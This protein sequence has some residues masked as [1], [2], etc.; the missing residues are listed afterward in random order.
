MNDQERRKAL[1]QFLQARRERLSPEAVGLPTS[2]RRRTP[3]LR[4]EE[5]ALIAG[6]GLTWYTMLEQGRD[7]HVSQQIL[8]SLAQ[9]LQLSQVERAHLFSLAQQSIV[10]APSMPREVVSPFLQRFLDQLE[11]GPAY[12]TGRRWDLLAWNRA[13]CEVLGDFQVL[14]EAE[15]NIVWFIFTDQEFRRRVGDWEGVAQRVLAQFRVSC[16]QGPGDPRFADLIERL[17][18]RREEIRA[19]AIA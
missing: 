14:A 17:T 5:L 2:S 11:P 4:R 19:L 1:A 15:R 12:I 9:A 8:E 16:G 6:I 18:V 13:A 3:G 10:P 7:I